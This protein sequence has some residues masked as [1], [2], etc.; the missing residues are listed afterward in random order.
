MHL[1]FVQ[2]LPRW[3]QAVLVHKLHDGDQ[4][5][6]AVLQR[7]AGQHQRVGAADALE[8]ARSDRVPVFDALRFICDDEIG[9]PVG[10]QVCVARQRFV[11]DDLA[12]SLLAILRLAL[13]PQPLDDLRGAGRKAR[14][15]VLPL[16][17]Q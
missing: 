15:F 4:F 12:K 6:Q 14:E 17:L 16:L 10:D 7:C 8:F 13:S 2:Q 5:L 1:V 11:V 9:C 3:P